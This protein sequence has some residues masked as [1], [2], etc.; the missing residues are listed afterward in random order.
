MIPVYERGEYILKLLP[1]S[2]WSFEP[3]QIELNID[4]E[5]DPCTLNHDLNFVFK[6]F[7]LAGRV[8]GLQK[9]KKKKKLFHYLIIYLGYKCRQYE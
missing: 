7:G 1:P 5:T 4:G 6:G 8:C 2:G 3:T 9:K